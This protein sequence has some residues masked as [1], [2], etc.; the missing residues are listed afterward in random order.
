MAKKTAASEQARA[1]ALEKFLRDSKGEAML[2]A[3][4]AMDVDAIATGVLSLDV[5]LGVG[6]VP[7]GRIIELYGP[8]HSG[9]TSVCLAIAGAVHNAGGMVGFID[10]EHA[11]DPKWAETF[12]VTRDR[13]VINQPMSGEDGL[14]MAI[15]MAAS[16][17]FDLIIVDSVAALVPQAEIDGEMHD[18]LVGVHARMMSKAMRKMTAIASESNTTVMFINQ[19]R[20]KIGGYGNPETTTGGKALKFYA[21]VRLEV[22]SPAGNRLK[23]GTDVYGQTIRV[24]VVK[25]K[26]ASPFVECEFDL[27][28][29]EGIDKVGCVLSAAESCGAVTRPKGSSKYTIATTGEQIP[30][31][32]K[33]NVKAYLAQDAE[34]RNELVEAVYA[35]INGLEKTVVE[36]GSEDMTDEEIERELVGA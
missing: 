7:K 35:A 22:R 17:A 2:L 16:G 32:G 6:G 25:N 3:D 34:M 9:K 19:I 11:L 8:E 26:V 1:A 21:S 13:V 10:A 36:D 12:G 27:I 24:K 29:G 15:N 31:T 14:D 4:A 20:E 18:Q 5:A 23:N 28:F 30:A 33:D